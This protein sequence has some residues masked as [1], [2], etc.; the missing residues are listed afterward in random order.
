MKMTK[1]KLAIM[2]SGYMQKY[3]AQRIDVD[4][5]LLSRYVRGEREAPKD[6]LK[7]LSKVLK[8]PQKEIE[9]Y[10]SDF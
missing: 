6:I 10:T 8:V 2:K 3:L 9:G 7:K 1:L 5:S 4:P